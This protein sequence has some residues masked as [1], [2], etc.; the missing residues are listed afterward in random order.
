MSTTTGLVALVTGVVLV[1]GAA[2]MFVDGLLG[3]A[4]AS[5]SRRSPRQRR[6]ARARCGRLR[7]GTLGERD[8]KT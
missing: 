3:V 7:P 5:V 2:D 4:G 1:V 8:S 6:C